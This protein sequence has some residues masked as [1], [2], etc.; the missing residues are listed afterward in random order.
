MWS[1]Q[2]AAGETEWFTIDENNNIAAHAGV[3]ASNENLE[4]FATGKELAKLA[5]DWPATR[6]VET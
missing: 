2:H 3:P 1:P 5:A 6:L 4:T